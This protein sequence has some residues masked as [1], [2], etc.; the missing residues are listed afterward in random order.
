[1]SLSYKPFFKLLID[2]EIKASQLVKEGVLSRSTMLK[3]KKGEYV[4]LDVLDKLCAFLQCQPGD[5]L[6]HVDK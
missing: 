1:M 2:K 6:E 3:M 5:I 4:S